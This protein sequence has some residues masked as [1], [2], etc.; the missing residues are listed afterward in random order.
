M[1]S[2]LSIEFALSSRFV[3]EK[4]KNKNRKPDCKNAYLGQYYNSVHTTCTPN[5]IQ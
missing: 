1:I 5:C 2:M 4:G 3:F